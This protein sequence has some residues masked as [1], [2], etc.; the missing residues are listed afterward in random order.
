MIIMNIQKNF[1]KSLQFIKQNKGTFAIIIV[2]QIIFLIL[3]SFIAGYYSVAILEKTSTI[4][5]EFDNLAPD[6][7]SSIQN[8]LK[9]YQ[10]Y[11]VLATLVLYFLLISYLAYALINGIVWELTNMILTNKENIIRHQ[12]KFAIISFFFFAI[13]AI[14]TRLLWA[15]SIKLGSIAISLILMTLIILAAMYFMHLSFVL[16]PNYT[17]RQ[18]KEHIK[19]VFILGKNNIKQI[20]PVFLISLIIPAIAFYIIYLINPASLF[21]II[22]LI[23]LFA[24]IIAICRLFYVTAVNEI[25]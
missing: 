20:L 22:T 24:A 10:E 5:Q 3:M 12:V 6:E 8:I 2:I 4:I 25:L 13:T 19:Q 17:L 11:G 9:I 14:T 7:S 1:K 23:I 15:L 21:L 16:I 18:T